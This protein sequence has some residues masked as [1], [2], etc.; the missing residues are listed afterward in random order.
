MSDRALIAAAHLGPVS[1]VELPEDEVRCDALPARAHGQAHSANPSL[2]SVSRSVSRAT[3]QPTS[4][5]VT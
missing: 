4:R 3:S 5:R 1:T 2:T